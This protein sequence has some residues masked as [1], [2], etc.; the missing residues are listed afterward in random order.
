MN[1]VI[2]G[3]G[4]I[5][6]TLADQL[7]LEGH[8]IS[9]VDTS[10]DALEKIDTLDLM[11]VEG[12]GL[13]KQIQEQANVPNADLVIA[14]MRADEQNLMACMIATKLGARNTVAR[15]RNPK[16]ADSVRLIRDGIHLGMVLNPERSSADEIARILRTPSAI[17]VDTF[18]KGRVEIQ[19]VRIPIGSK[20]DGLKLS[21]LGHIQPGV[22][23]CIVERGNKEVHIPNGNFVLRGGDQI[24]LIA[25]PKVAAKFFHKIDMPTTPIRRVMLLGGGRISYYLA[26]QLLEYG[27]TDVKIIERDKETCDLLS[28]QLPRVSVIE[29]DA[30]KEKQL[31]DEGIEKMDAVISLTGIDE[32]NI[33]M[34]LFARSTSKAKIIT[35]INRT[36]FAHVVKS[37]DIGSVFHPRYIAAD[38]IVRYVRAL[39]NS[40]GSNV[41]TL[42]KIIGNQAEALEFRATAKSSVCGRTLQDLPLRPNLL[43]G[44]INRNGVILT[45]GGQ[46]TIEPGDTVVVVTGNTGLNDLD[47]ILDRR[48]A[49]V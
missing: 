23:I 39:Q 33:M 24:S 37:L 17:K 34:S 36:T 3:A 21:D 44:A 40:F 6:A 19:K 38:I 26:K 46:D 5:G 22:L 18:A 25:K 10:A 41:E 30:T 8:D 45:P 48:R 35:K 28:E 14:T 31:R 4:K 7:A 42:Y 12:D 49:R 9:V 2:I 13:T 11:T 29:G 27:A 16:Y 1:I 15:V 43:I 47:D 32:E 20:L